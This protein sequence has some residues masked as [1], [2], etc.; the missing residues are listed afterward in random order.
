MATETHS[1]PS[2]GALFAKAAVSGGERVVLVIILDFFGDEP[3]GV[4]EGRVGRGGVQLRERRHV[5][6]GRDA[7]AQAVW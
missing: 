1:L 2:V 6:A 4:R 7:R 3:T 5:H